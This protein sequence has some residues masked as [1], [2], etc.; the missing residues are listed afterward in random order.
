MEFTS[1]FTDNFSDEIA[2]VD[3]NRN[4]TY[5]QFAD[6][7]LRSASFFKTHGIKKLLL[8]LPQNFHSYALVIGAYI[9]GTT[10][11]PVNSLLTE[12]RKSYFILQFEPDLI[13]SE[14]RAFE[15]IPELP[16]VDIQYIFSSGVLCDKSS[17][18]NFSGTEIAYVIFT[19]GSTGLPKGVKVTRASLENFLNWSTNEY[20]V[21][22]GDK[23]AQYSNLGFD[24]CIC[25]I[26]TVIE[27]IGTLVIFR[28]LSQKLF[29]GN[30]IKVQQI[31]FW[32]SVPT[33]LDFLFERN[34]I[35]H[36]ILGQVKVM[37]FCGEPLYPHQLKLLF[38]AN[39]DLIV[40]NTYGPT[41]GTIFCTFSKLTI[42]NYKDYCGKTVSIGNPIPGYK[43]RLDNIEK[44]IGEIVILSNYVSAGYLNEINLNKSFSNENYQGELVSTY[45]TGDFGYYHDGHLYFAQRKDAQIKIMGHRIDLSEIDYYIRE[46][47]YKTCVTVYRQKKIISFIK[48]DSMEEKKLRK[49]LRVKLPSY[50]SPNLIINTDTFPYSENLKINIQELSN[51]ILNI[52]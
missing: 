21:K 29:P 41:E 44:S 50:Y 13:I 23:W 40:Y 8:D 39:K 4:W 15:S 11:C 42:D 30:H 35:T 45:H 47:G 37:T 17:F 5:R 49:Y 12:A 19:S 46:F 9:S 24:L 33:V 27:C 36:E 18:N 32:Q 16:V 26:F 31:K 52:F 34:H 25:D 7:V 48:S 6:H 14:D 51:S 28:D 20:G 43:I 2:V 38:E 10:F 22:T 1:I 3:G